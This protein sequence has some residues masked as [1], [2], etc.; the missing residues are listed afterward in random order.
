MKRTR[1]T[2]SIIII[3]IV[4][5]IPYLAYP[6]TTFVLHRGKRLI[7]GR[8]LDWITGT[9]L[10]MTN[11]RGVSKT[12]LMDP[13]EDPVSW[14]SKYGSITFNQV[15]R[16]LP[17][18][19][20]N[21]A[22]LVVEH[23]TLDETIYPPKDDRPAIGALQWIQYQLD[24]YSTVEEVIHSDSLLRIVDAANKIH[25]LVCDR[26]GNVTTVEFLNGKM[27]YHTG[28][29][30]PVEVLAN[31]TYEKSIVCYNDNCDTQ[32][33]RSLFN[34]C[35][36]TNRIHQFESLSGDDIIG[37]A[38]KILDNVRQGLL[39][40]WSVVYDITNMKIYFKVFETPKIV[41][42]QKIFLKRPG[43]AVVKV[44]DVRD[45]NFSCSNT[46]Q[47]LDLNSDYEG[48]VDHYFTNYSTSINKNF[49][50][51]VFT[52]F[53]GWGTNIQLPDE[54][55]NSMAKYPESFGCIRDRK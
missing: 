30:L 48:P 52:F 43:E 50:D 2:V 22:G 26:F 6:C 21:E 46:P 33:N 11:P 54:V 14:V 3:T 49:I 8:N 45:F 47:V 20:I 36:A 31:S 17:Y 27:V 39:T 34:F 28:K 18:G 15:G 37:D 24:N 16:D 25:F 44:V 5:L 1:L 55:L 12:A 51:E 9:G 35:T 41:G 23:M 7:F 29:D 32:S 10:I 19:G 38:F 4:A 53:K 13:A 40:K 42:K